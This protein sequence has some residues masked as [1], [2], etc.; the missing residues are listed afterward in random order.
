MRSI[1]LRNRKKEIIAYTLV[2]DEDYEW[3]NQWKWYMSHGYA[4]R[5]S[6]RKL[7]KNG[8]QKT[9]SMSVEIMKYNH[10]WEKGK[11]VD[12]INRQKLDNQKS[13]LRM[14]TKSQNQ[15]NMGLRKNNTSGYKGVCYFPLNKTNPWMAYVSYN[16]KR[17]HL[18]YFSSKESAARVYDKAAIKY[19]GEF[20]NTN[21]K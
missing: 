16:R 13:N 17:I 10:L 9:I 18:G 3:L 8:K 19:F 14:A 12:H 2:D 4:I 15:C 1:P 21:L 7:N 6:S 5:A 11:E 20:V